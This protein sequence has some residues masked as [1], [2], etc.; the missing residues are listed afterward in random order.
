MWAYQVKRDVLTC[1][2][3]GVSCEHM[4]TKE[5]A[6]RHGAI[7]IDPARPMLKVSE[8]AAV[9][10]TSRYTIYRLMK[11]GELRYHL[12]GEDRRIAQEELESYLAR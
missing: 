9:L 10:N 12:V 7:K 5:D 3:I 11:S 1:I 8:A 2:E 6:K 4:A